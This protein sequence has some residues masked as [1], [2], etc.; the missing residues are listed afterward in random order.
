MV[1]K[2]HTLPNSSRGQKSK[3]FSQNWSQDVCPSVFFLKTLGRN[4]FIP[5]HLLKAAYTLSSQ[6]HHS[7]ICF[8]TSISLIMTLVD[9]SYKDSCNYTE[10]TKIFQG[11]FPISSGGCRRETSH[12][13]VHAPLVFV[14]ILMPTKLVIWQLVPHL[15]EKTWK[16]ERKYF[17]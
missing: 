10:T 8:Y 15:P 7:S 11:N 17:N 5:L 2:H 13:T 4:P 16:G 14:L 1:K 6:P 3:W 12:S 9:P